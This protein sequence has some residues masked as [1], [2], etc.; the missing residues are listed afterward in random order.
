DPR[1]KILREM[2]KTASPE[3]H[4]TAARTEEVALKILHDA[5]PERPNATNVDFWASVVLTGAG[6]PKELFTC[7]F[8]TSRVAGWTAHVLESPA[9]GPRRA[10]LAGA[11]ARRFPDVDDGRDQGARGAAARHRPD[12]CLAQRGLGAGRRAPPVQAKRASRG[13]RHGIVSH[14]PGHVPP[15]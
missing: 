6:I 8:A 9:A 11:R 2:A 12:G 3:L 14:D 13:S 4:R 5:H 10:R 15:Q 1:A 7:L